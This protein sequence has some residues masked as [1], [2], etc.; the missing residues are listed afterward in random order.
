MVKHQQLYYG[1]QCKIAF[2]ECVLNDE[3]NRFVRSCSDSI[4][5]SLKTISTENEKL[6]VLY[7]ETLTIKDLKKFISDNM[8]ADILH[9]SAHGRYDR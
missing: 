3:Q 1:K 2:A 7:C 6:Q 8:D 4:V 9:I 5:H